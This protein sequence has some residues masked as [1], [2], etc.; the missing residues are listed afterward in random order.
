MKEEILEFI[1]RRFLTDCDWL[2]GNCYYFAAILA[3]RF[4]GSHIYYD[5]VDGHFFIR[6]LGHCYDWTGVIE[7]DMNKCILWEEFTGYDSLQKK[8]I[9]RDCILQEDMNE[10]YQ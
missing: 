5:T 9:I 10:N 4:P 7:P 1:H 6:N 3:I 2:T 8:R